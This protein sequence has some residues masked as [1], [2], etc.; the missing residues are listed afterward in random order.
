MNADGAEDDEPAVL[1]SGGAIM[2][3]LEQK[4][5]PTTAKTAKHKKMKQ[6]H[7]K[8][9]SSSNVQTDIDDLGTTEQ[10]VG[11]SAK[12]TFMDGI[13]ESTLTHKKTTESK[14][15]RH[16]NSFEQQ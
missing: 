14:M 8:T 7:T 1:G 3:A 4:D 5:K 16:L 9:D 2:A 10:S 12:N 15:K 6:K 13:V 11:Q